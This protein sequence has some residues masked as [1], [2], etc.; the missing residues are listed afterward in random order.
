MVGWGDGYLKEKMMITVYVV[1]KT[2][3][4]QFVEVEEIFI[5]QSKAEK[6]AKRLNKVDLDT[7]Y[8]YE[9]YPWDVVL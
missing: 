9:V 8:V 7:E 5:R 3:D 1:V 2:C 4:G 6:C